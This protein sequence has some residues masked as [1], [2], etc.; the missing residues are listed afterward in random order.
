M[1]DY[2]VLHVFHVFLA[3]AQSNYR[4]F[5]KCRTLVRKCPTIIDNNK[6][7]CIISLVFVLST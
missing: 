6:N 2:P 5:G 1:S 7:A 4:L 3:I